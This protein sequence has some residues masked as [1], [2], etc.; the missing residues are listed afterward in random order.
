[1]SPSHSK[2]RVPGGHFETSLCLKWFGGKLNFR[3][4]FSVLEDTLKQAY[5]LNGLR[6]KLNFRV[7]FS[8][9]SKRTRKFKNKS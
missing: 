3:V 9:I 7:S 4:S 5:L 6:G 8:V 1:M 2:T